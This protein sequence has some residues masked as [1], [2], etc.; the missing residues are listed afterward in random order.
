MFEV[1]SKGYRK[2][3]ALLGLLRAYDRGIPSLCWATH[4]CRKDCMML[5]QQDKMTLLEIYMESKLLKNV[6]MYT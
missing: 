6:L 5:C 4:S 3:D 1:R 2:Y